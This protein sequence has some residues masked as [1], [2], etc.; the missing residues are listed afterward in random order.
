MTT[1]ISNAI[2]TAASSTTSNAASSALLGNKTQTNDPAAMQDRFLKL[3]VAQMNNQ[4]PMSP[5]DNAQLT[6]QMAQ[7]NTVSGIQELNQAVSNI[8]SQFGAMQMLQGSGLIGRDVMY[9]GNQLNVQNGVAK[10]AVD[11]AASV[12][13]LK[14]QITNSAGTVL[15]TVALGAKS[16]GRTSFSWDASSYTGS[17]NVYMK[18]VA[19]AGGKAMDATGFVAGTVKSVGA[20]TKG[21][22][23]LQ[24]QNGQQLSYSDVQSIL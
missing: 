23:S 24:L 4:D 16:A 10:G 11:L 9:A 17:G 8:S 19:T 13:D 15:D 2:S 6:S 5:M 7:I 1:A 18:V 22:L 20:D 3:L 12:E 14:I 21:A